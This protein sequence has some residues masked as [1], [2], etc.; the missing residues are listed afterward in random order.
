VAAQQGHPDVASLLLKAPG[1]SINAQ[2]SGGLTPLHLA[3]FQRRWQQ[4]SAVMRLL[5]QAGADVY[6]VSAAGQQALHCAV[7]T[8]SNEAVQQLLEAGAHNNEVHARGLNS[9]ALAAVSGDL[10][11]VQMLQAAGV[12]SSQANWVFN[13]DA[14]AIAVENGDLPIVNA[15]LDDRRFPVSAQTLKIVAACSMRLN[16]MKTPCPAIPAVLQRHL[17]ATV[18]QAGGDVAAVLE[19]VHAAVGAGHDRTANTMALLEGWAG[20]TGKADAAHVALV[21]EV[22]AHSMLTQVAQDLL[23]QYAAAFQ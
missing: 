13:H 8:G 20:N 19:Q 14:L 5:L 7:K 4:Q 16:F 23:L 6:V 22:Q 10:P 1:I 18:Q 3:A 2:A 12:R 15:L 17:A 21:G 9:L 11:V